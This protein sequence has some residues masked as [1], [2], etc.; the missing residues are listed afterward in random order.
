MATAATCCWERM[1]RRL[2]RK[3]T[4]ASSRNGKPEEGHCYPVHKTI[5][6]S[7][8]CSVRYW[9]WAQNYYQHPTEMHNITMSCRPW[10]YL[11]GDKPIREFGPLALKPVRELMVTGYEHPKYGRQRGL[12]RK[13]IN[14]RI[15][16]IKR[17]IKYGV[18]NE[19]VPSSVY[20]ALQAV[21]GLRRGKTE[22]KESPKVKPVAG[23][24]R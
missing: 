2:A 14:D 21:P 24:R 7:T 10:K 8:N 3:S 18:E 5:S 12:C 23:I 20:Q 6:A 4:A 16:R 15:G 13:N 19:L 9:D 17:I 1:A 22:A 11:Y